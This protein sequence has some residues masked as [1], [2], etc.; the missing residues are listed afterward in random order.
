M[1]E[2]A[3]G[4]RVLYCGHDGYFMADIFLIA[5]ANVVKAT[6]KVTPDNIIRP[7]REATHHLSDFPQARCWSP[8]R[9][10]F[11]VPA[12]QVRILENKED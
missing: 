12:S 11:V 7:G 3:M 1:S 4:A 9:G 6:G 8:E 5:G 10:I 2:S